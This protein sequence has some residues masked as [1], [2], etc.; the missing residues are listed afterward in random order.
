M[1]QLS[2]KEGVILDHIAAKPCI[3]QRDLSRITG[4]SLGCVNAIIKKLTQTGHIQSSSPNKKR[5]EYTLTSQGLLETT[6][7]AHETALSIVKSFKTIQSRLAELL[8][9]LHHSGY[10]YFSIHGDG[11]LKDLLKAT[12]FECLEDAPVTLGEKEQ[13]H[14]RAIILNVSHTSLP[15]DFKGNVVN[16]MERLSLLSVRG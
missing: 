11:E 9:R 4:T 14:P 15:P 12:F 13:D 10:D 3:S 5:P 1:P 2:D 7:K 8:T 16:V 6:Q